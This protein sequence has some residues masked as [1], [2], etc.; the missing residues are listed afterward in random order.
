M[1][2]KHQK[3]K[4]KRARA[5]KCLDAHLKSPTSGGIQR[6]TREDN[7]RDHDRHNSPEAEN[8]GRSERESSHRSVSRSVSHRSASSGHE[9]NARSRRDSSRQSGSRHSRRE[10]RSRS[11]SSRRAR[12]SHESRRKHSRRRRSSS[13]EPPLWAKELLSQQ[14][15]NADEL[16]RL[17]SKMA[18]KSSEGPSTAS[19][20]TD[21]EFRYAGNKKQYDVNQSVIKHLDHALAADDQDEASKQINAVPERRVLAFMDML[22]RV[23]DNSFIV[24]ARHLAQLTGSLSSM[25]LALGPVVRLWTRELYRAIQQSTSWDQRFQLSE[26]GKN[27]ICFWHENFANSGQPIWTACPTIDVMTYSDASDVACGGYAVQL[28]GQT[29]VGSWS[30]EESV[31]SSTFRELRAA[32]LV[33][34]SMASQLEGREV[35]HRT[36][37]QSAERIMTVGSRNPDLHKEAILLYKICRKHNIRLSVE[38]VSRNQNETA[39]ALSRFDDPDDYKLDPSVFRA[40]DQLWGPHT[41]DRFASMITTQ[42]PRFSSKYMNPKCDSTDAFTVCWL[43]ENNWLFPPPY[44]IPRVIRHMSANKE[45]GTLLIPYWPSAP[46]WP[47][48][49]TKQGTWNWFV[50]DCLDISPY[51][52]IFITG[53]LSSNIFTTGVPPFELRA[54]RLQFG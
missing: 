47:L 13:D 18:K 19:K 22:K 53:S 51:N 10:I 9:R 35:R 43:G 23:V 29:A 17:K 26:D 3:T 21:H 44:L 15:K 28:G 16:R 36:D 33:L 4:E 48:L 27:E 11:S 52:G 8:P 7:Q 38:W 24:S 20:V 39:D 6:K 1:M 46:W 45:Y 34:Q 42:L 5:L 31:Q 32:R 12:S 54:L 14:K 37:N 50:T 41:Y 2:D 30:E 49:I 25:G 40:I